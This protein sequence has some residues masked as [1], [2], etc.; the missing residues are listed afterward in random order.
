MSETQEVIARIVNLLVQSLRDSGVIK[1][2]LICIQGGVGEKD[3]NSDSDEG[4]NEAATAHCLLWVIKVHIL[5]FLIINY[6]SL[7]IN[8]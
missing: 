2:I 5:L 3:E 8:W 6:N 1:P 4:S 7:V